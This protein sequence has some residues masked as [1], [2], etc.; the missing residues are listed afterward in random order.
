MVIKDGEIEKV[1]SGKYAFRSTGAL[2]I[3]VSYD[4]VPE[5]P[6]VETTDGALAGATDGILE[7]PACR[8]KPVGGDLILNQIIEN[9]R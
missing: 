9:V 8:V 6:F 3:E 1:T 7:L 4:A 5:D 2:S